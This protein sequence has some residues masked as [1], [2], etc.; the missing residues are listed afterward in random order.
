MTENALPTITELLDPTDDFRR[1]RIAVGAL[2]PGPWGHDIEIKGDE[3]NRAYCEKCEEVWPAGRDDLIEDDCPVPDSATGSLA[4]ISDRLAKKVDALLE[5]LPPIQRDK[6][7]CIIE[8]YV[9]FAH[10][11]MRGGDLHHRIWQWFAMKATPVERICC[12]LVALGKAV[13]A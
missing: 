9:C 7:E 3:T 6:F 11:F 1:L 13:V 5:S 8:D 12:C 10:G 2:E 4:E